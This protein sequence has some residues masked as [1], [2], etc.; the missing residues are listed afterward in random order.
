MSRCFEHRTLSP[1]FSTTSV[2]MRLIVSALLGYRRLRDVRYFQN[3][4]LVLRI[5]S[6]RGM[7]TASTL[8]RQ[9]NALGDRI[10]G[11]FEL[12]QQRLVLDA[13]ER[14]QLSRITLDFDG[15]VLGTCRHAE[16]VASG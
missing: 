1:I 12:L 6:V 16:G 11:L 4:P 2:A 8:S 9:L 14:E 3:D 7:S 13:L 10:I 5:L 15:S